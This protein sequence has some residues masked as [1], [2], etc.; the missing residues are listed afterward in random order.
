MKT[1]D[2]SVKA[3]G[4]LQG[5]VGDVAFDSTMLTLMADADS[6]DFVI[7]A[8]WVALDGLERHLTFY[9]PERDQVQKVYRFPSVEGAGAYYEIAGER[10][11]DWQGGTIT[12]EQV[13]FSS[14]DLQQ[15][16]AAIQFSFEVSVDGATIWIKGEGRLT[17]ASPW[18]RGMRRQ[19]PFRKD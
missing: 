17:G 7:Q 4:Y 8:G 2:P 9:L 5:W 14:P 13:D 19:F 12:Q 15:W 10:T 16:Y 1:I 18:G 3:T 11:M 6:E